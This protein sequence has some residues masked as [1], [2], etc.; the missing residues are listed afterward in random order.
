[1]PPEQEVGDSNVSPC[2]QRVKAFQ[3][4]LTRVKMP[5][6]MPRYVRQNTT[7]I[8]GSKILEIKHSKALRDKLKLVQLNK[9][10]ESL[11]HDSLAAKILYP[12]GM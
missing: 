3:T 11:V 12:H 10:K 4:N 2:S 8:D 6:N 9:I 5:Q 1:M 7:R